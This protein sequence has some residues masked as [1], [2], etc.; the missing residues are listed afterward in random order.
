M[1]SDP[2]VATTSEEDEFI[3]ACSRAS[4]ELWR[5]ETDWI[6][7]FESVLTDEVIRPFINSGKTLDLG[8]EL[9]RFWEE[10]VACLPIPEQEAYEFVIATCD[11]L[12]YFTPE[13]STQVKL[14]RRLLVAETFYRNA[15][16]D[17]RHRWIISITAIVRVAL[18]RS[19]DWPSTPLSETFHDMKYGFEE[20]T[21][22]EPSWPARH[23]GDSKIPYES[24]LRRFAAITDQ[25]NVGSDL[26]HY[27]IHFVDATTL[28]DSIRQAYKGSDESSIDQTKLSAAGQIF[29]WGCPLRWLL[30]YLTRTKYNPS[31]VQSLEDSLDAISPARISELL[32]HIESMW[33]ALHDDGRDIPVDEIVPLLEPIAYLPRVWYPRWQQLIEEH[34]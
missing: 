26:V 15:D 18:W 22:P 31:R 19:V 23:C 4:A 2:P 27:F 25:A 1:P 34:D 28:L 29:E 14:Q 16:L 12:D 30:E 5:G 33:I 3:L 24:L 9:Q 11:P 21:P 10:Q 8:A 17:R 32:N 20:P 7:D 13:L 6:N